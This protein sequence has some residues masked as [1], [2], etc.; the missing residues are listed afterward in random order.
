MYK[1]YENRV[2]NFIIDMT[3]PCSKIEHKDV[4]EKVQNTRMELMNERES[5]KPFIFKGYITE[6]DRINDTIKR[7]KYLYFC[8][9]YDQILNKKKKLNSPEKYNP[10]TS[11]N[12]QPKKICAKSQNHNINQTEK[13]P[14]VINSIVS[15]FK[16]KQKLTFTERQNQS[17]NLSMNLISQPQMRFK[18]RTDLERVY[19][20]LNGYFCDENDKNILDRQLRS[21]NL[22]NVKRIIQKTSNN[23]SLNNSAN[24]NFNTIKENNNSEIKKGNSLIK[25]NE[26]NKNK[27]QGILYRTN[28]LY[29]DRKSEGY[30]PW[31]RRED[32]NNEATGLLK[33]YY[34][35]THFKAAEEIAENNNEKKQK[36]KKSKNKS[37]NKNSIFLLPN[38]FPNFFNQKPL[39]TEGNIDNENNDPFKF[40]QDDEE[41]E[42][43]SEDYDDYENNC[44]PL[45]QNKKTQIDPKS[46]K[47]LTDIAFHSKNYGDHFNYNVDD[48]DDKK[49]LKKKDDNKNFGEEN[50]VTIG[51]HTYFKNSQFD[52]ISSKVLGMCNIYSTKSKFNNTSLKAREGKTMITNGMTV[53]DF[54]KKYGLEEI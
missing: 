16:K 4:T 5:K 37:T 24:K 12:I 10:K 45:T 38:V 17:T 26:K 48:N 2:K 23:N 8:K 1:N 53:K 20:V 3:N 13:K 6:A 47:I 29:F 28:K 15:P 52:Q 39:K 11:Q 19:D 46:M 25:D 32:L 49:S 44:N 33:S 40:G 51:N 42:E 18:P 54:E 21:I 43:I 30:K 35:K 34:Y 27:K 36:N 41:S 50:S 7:N 22:N 9:D 31:V 14:S